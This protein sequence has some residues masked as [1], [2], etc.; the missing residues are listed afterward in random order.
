MTNT[1]IFLLLL[2][3]A[4]SAVAGFAQA[5]QSTLYTIVEVDRFVAAQGVD[6]P[7]D[8]QIALLE[9]IIREAKRA[10]KG[11]EI[12]REGESAPPGRTMMRISGTI[13]QFK[14][15]SRAKRYLIGFGAGS[16]VVKAHV[17]FTDA[18]SGAVLAE[19][20]LK[21]LTW[22]GIAGGSS[23]GAA[24]RLGKHVVAAAKSNQLIPKK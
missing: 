9:D 19:K 15:G 22:I 11:I 24:D 5:R 16:T 13:T 18:A 10:A 8:Y 14:P 20:D 2:T 4:A 6:F 1:R 21:G 3:L 12:V 23:E 17:K 7:P